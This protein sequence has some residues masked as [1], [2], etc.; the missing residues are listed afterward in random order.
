MITTQRRHGVHIHN[1]FHN[2]YVEDEGEKVELLLIPSACPSF[3]LS[4]ATLPS[5][6]WISTCTS[7]DSTTSSVSC[8]APPESSTLITP[9]IQVTPSVHSFV[10]ASVIALR[11]L[12][13]LMSR[14]PEPTYIPI[15]L[16]FCWGMINYAP[17]SLTSCFTVSSCLFSVAQCKGVDPADSF[18]TVAMD[19]GTWSGM[20]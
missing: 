18:C 10:S 17:H 2:Y 11:P 14:I 7:P 9:T 6:S 15:K 3:M 4:F 16:G 19:D 5:A 13:F 1:H 20:R 12:L 8:A